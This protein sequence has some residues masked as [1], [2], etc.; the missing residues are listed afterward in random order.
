VSES[1]DRVGAGPIEIGRVTIDVSSGTA[2]TTT[3]GNLRSPSTFVNFVG[4]GGND[5]A[6]NFRHG[7]GEGGNDRLD[8]GAG[9]DRVDGGPGSDTLIGGPGDDILIGGPGSDEF[10]FSA[11]SGADTI[12]D[13]ADGTDTIAIP[14]RSFGALEIRAWS[15]GALVELD[16]GTIRVFGVSPANLTPADFDFLA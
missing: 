14:G 8:A 15:D 7:F 10:R 6:S 9:N 12:A 4:D 16:A 5:V 2:L 1:I 3:A 11:T 13:F